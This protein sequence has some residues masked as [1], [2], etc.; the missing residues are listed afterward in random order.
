M[1]PGPSRAAAC[2]SYQ[3]GI[4]PQHPRPRDPLRFARSH[5]F[6]AQT[7]VGFRSGPL[8]EIRRARQIRSSAMM[9]AC[10]GPA[11][12][13]QP[14]PGTIPGNLHSVLRGAGPSDSLQAAPA[15]AGPRAC[16]AARAP[17]RVTPTKGAP[18]EPC[19]RRPRTSPPPAARLRQ[20]RKILAGTTSA[21]SNDPCAHA[22]PASRSSS[23]FQPPSRAAAA[24]RRWRT[25]PAQAAMSGRRACSTRPRPASSAPSR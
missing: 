16:R 10:S 1:P 19:P 5:R 6:A 3:C 12:R 23:T 9:A 8:S 2:G 4:G 7:R 13:L 21:V 17:R 20:L 15:T 18:G 25:T 24:A 11:G 14:R 22:R